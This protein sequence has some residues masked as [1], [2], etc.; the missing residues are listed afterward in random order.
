MI[1]SILKTKK[2]QNQNIN[3]K[4]KIMMIIIIIKLNSILIITKL[5]KISLAKKWSYK[6]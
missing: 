3:T 1:M 5:M 2:N 4:K 6:N